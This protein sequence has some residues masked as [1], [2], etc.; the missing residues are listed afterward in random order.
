MLNNYVKNWVETMN[1]ILKP[2][3]ELVTV[4]RRDQFFVA[5]L[6]LTSFYVLSAAGILLISSVATLLIFSPRDTATPLQ[7]EVAHL[8]PPHGEWSMYEVREHLA[9]VILIVDG[10]I[11]ILVGLLSYTFARRTLVPLRDMHEAQQRFMSDAAHELRT[12]LAVMQIGAETLLRQP[13]SVPEYEDFV[14]DVHAESKRLTRLSNQLLQLLKTGEQSTV[15]V[16]PENISLLLTAE[17]ARFRPYAQERRVTLVSEVAMGIMVRTEKDSVIEI[18]QNVLKNA[19]DYNKPDGTVTILT[20]IQ[21]ETLT[22][23]ITDTGI[24]ITPALQQAVF[25]RFTKADFAR[26]QHETSGAGLG[27]SIVNALVS[28]IGGSIVLESAVG[29]GTTVSISLPV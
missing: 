20:T 2:F 14:T 11:M 3:G 6:K 9:T 25:D 10:V 24:G 27:L 4:L 16:A 7:L 26:T 8:E 12:P 13:R 21:G 17:I 22:V 18:I 23:A 1:S 19:I 15:V 28:R 29:K 5:T